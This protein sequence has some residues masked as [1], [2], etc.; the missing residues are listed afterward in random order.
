MQRPVSGDALHSAPS[1]AARRAALER[2]LRQARDGDG[3]VGIPR[4]GAAEGPL[5][6]AQRRLWL[7]EQLAPG[8][9]AYLMPTGHR[10]RGTLDAPALERALGELVR[11]HEAFRTSFVLR[12]GEPVQVVAP[13]CP[14]SLAV[15]DLSSLDAAAREAVVARHVA[16]EA[17]RPFD[18][19]RP[20]LLRATLLR[21]GPEEHVLLL[22]THHL[23]SDG[24][25][26]G[27]MMHDLAALYA[28]FAGGQAPPPGPAARYLDYATWQAERLAGD[29][30][31]RDLAYWRAQL[32]DAP[33]FLELPVDAAR[34]PVESHR[35]ALARAPL[36]PAL[37]AGVAALARGEGATPLAVH[38]AAWG[39][40]LS[41]YAGQP[42]VTVGTPLACRTRPE[43]E[44]V[45]GLFVNTLPLR[46][47][48][49]D[50]PSFRALVG[51]VREQLL[52]AQ[53]HADLPFERLLDAVGVERSLAWP[54]L[55]QAVCVRVEADAEALPLP[56]ITA[57]PLATDGP[58]A[59]FE[60]T[61]GVLEG[62]ADAVLQLEYAA[63]LFTAATAARVLEH[64]RVLLER[65]LA[66]PDRRLSRVPLLAR[67]D[68]ALLRGPA[69]GAAEAPVRECIHARFAAQAAATPD[70]VAVV[71][72][73]LRLTYRELDERAGRLAAHLRRHGAGPEV[74][75]GVCL[76]RS[77]GLI[78]AVLGVL[79]AGAA[80]VPLDPAYPP[81]RLA[82]LL[83]DSAAPLLVTSAALL[84]HLP[85]RGARAV[86]LD[87]D[88]DAIA[89]EPALAAGE[90]AGP[91]GLAYVIYTSGSTGRPKGVMVEHRQVV[92]L[93]RATAEPVG[94]RADDAWSFFHSAA[95]DM[96]VWE[97]W[98][99]LLCGAR[100]VVVP[101][102]TSRDPASLLELLARERVTVLNQTPS[103]FRLLVE[104]DARAATDGAAPEL[105]L[106]LVTFGGEALDPRALAPWVARRG[107]ARPLLG[108][109]YGITETTVHA[110]WRRITRA[111]VAHGAG[112]PIG[113]PLSDLSLYLLDPHGLPVPAGVAGE[114][115]VGGAGVARGYLGRPSL[116]AQRFLP[117]PFA[118]AAGARMYRSGDRARRLAD[119][120]LEYLGRLDQQVKV[121]GFRIEPAEVEAAL[122]TH[123]AVRR[124]L[125]AAFGAPGEAR[126][127]AYVAADPPGPGADELRGHLLPRL[128]EHMIPAAFVRVDAFPLTA[129]G[130]LDRRALPAPDFAAAQRSYLAPRTPA[131][132]LLAALW[133]EVLEVERVGVHD[134][135]F[136]LGGDSIRSIRL[137]ARLREH[138]A[139]LSLADLVRHP[140]V[141]AAAAL[142]GTASPRDGGEETARPFALLSPADRARMPEDV[143]DAYPL[144]LLQTGMLFH[145]EL[146][147]SALYHNVGS[148]RVRA[149]WD[150]ACFRDALG[151]E[152]ARHPV[153]RTSFHLAGFGE[154]LQ[155]V[156]RSV[157]LPLTVEDLR[158]LAPAEQDAAVDA[159]I[160]AERARPFAV[161][162][163]PLVRFHV[164]LRGDGTFQLGMTEHHAILDGWS[165]ALLTAELLGRYA[166]SGGEAAGAEPERC[167]YRDFVRRERQALA[168][169]DERRAWEGRLAGAV[170]GRL[171]RGAGDGVRRGAER[172]TLSGE[173][174]AAL[175]RAADQAGVP[176]K[177][178]LLAAHLRVMGALLGRREVTTGVLF[179]GRPEESGGDRLLGLFLNPLPFSLRLQDESWREL[180]RRTWRAEREILALR[181]FPAAELQRM[182]GGEPW[183]DTLFNLV[184]FRTDRHAVPAEG[185]PEV[186]EQRGVADTTFPLAAN[187]DLGSYPGRVH[188][189]LWYDAGRTAPGE[190]AALVRAYALAL[191]RIAADPGAGVGAAP[192]AGPADLARLRAWSDGGPG[193]GGAGAVHLL[194]AEQ[195][196]RTPR[197]VAL[198]W[199]GG[200]ATYAELDAW[201]GRLARA[202]ARRGVRRGSRVGVCLERSARRVAALLAVLKAGAA[203][204]ALEPEHPPGRTAALLADAGAVLL[205]TRDGVPAAAGIASVPA[206]APDG[207]E[208]DA[209]TGSPPGDAGAEAGPDD[210]ACVAYTSGSTGAPKGVAVTHRGVVRLARGSCGAGDGSREVWAQLAAVGFDASALEIW[211]ALLN[212]ARLAVPPPG[213][214]EPAEIGEFLRRS[215]VTT[216]FLTTALFNLVVDERPDALRPLARLLT[217]GEAASPDHVGRALAAHPGLRLANVYGPTENATLTTRHPAAPGDAEGGSVPIGRPVEGTHCH[218]LD[219][220]LHPAPVGM[221]GELFAGG[222]GVAA[223]YLGRPGA[224][225]ERFVPDPF[226]GLPGARMYRTGD[227]VRWRGDGVL[228]FLGRT[229]RQVKVRGVRVEPAE[230]EAALR[231]QPGVRDAV[232]DLLRGETGAARLVAWV[233]A[234]GP[235]APAPA[236]LR[237]A[238]RRTLPEAMVPAA[239]VAVDALPL[240][241]AG[242]VDRRALPDPGAAAPAR[243]PAP[244]RDEVEAALRTLWSEVLETPAV[245]VDDD[246]FDL[247]G[248]SLRVMRLVPRIREVF[249]VEL[250]I[251]DF[252]AA[253]TVAATARALA[254]REDRPGRTL[255][256]ARLFL[257]V[258]EMPEEE[259]Q[260]QLREHR[261]AAAQAAPAGSAA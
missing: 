91:A 257:Q 246:F 59:K 185:A 241:S 162:R 107:D 14:L 251:R 113:Q 155:L 119:G 83:E 1:A 201:A 69:S 255:R 66:D 36:P 19:E 170:P 141:A 30:L 199:D 226:S 189:E 139:A 11:R 242:K 143:E 209:E 13:A 140:T 116:T 88:A 216:A 253:R 240:T 160:A 103:A 243:P 224:T 100:V 87:R 48:L 178:L 81:E 109:L 60:L 5:S 188:L 152:A 49:G 41:R 57:Q 194:F 120:G 154:P 45:V 256:I 157:E 73:P 6:P 182:N 239:F 20:P 250:P 118:G 127:A 75:V 125:V 84:A 218:V 8:T 21:L 183:A 4:T 177:S 124:A 79:K 230:V 17:R 176:L 198:S 213:V 3:V 223:G 232:V 163:A 72:G 61:L 53:A 205:V 260:A 15:H 153:L 101:H 174:S 171:P 222:E 231:R 121:R 24:W 112:S 211:G 180:A 210:I 106:R 89:R 133:C 47:D 46:I 131:E 220:F 221:P 228:E 235:E 39:A 38:L 192:L 173:E 196:R 151:A 187:F 248:D 186:L 219:A 51:R 136:A 156:H 126:L 236:E 244:P 56:G 184:D 31:E 172:L 52:G 94:F 65:A 130:K 259:V 206:L 169:A 77:A 108:N 7:V 200:A 111:D 55:L 18:L 110:T 96:S 167:G 195:A 164:Q 144:S 68:E 114:L 82:Y 35:G 102:A 207:A 76:E 99:A 62:G 93:L 98:G 22:T 181:H 202:M 71:D 67:P 168:S 245:G 54:P 40:L 215:G 122:E 149:P 258:A 148:D 254:A 12:A 233:V 142:L 29:A 175:R 63:D 197:A 23:A 92:R 161:D 10:L 214:L 44:G 134:E 43:L 159:W 135:F 191:E 150:E 27:V 9:A 212:G 25:S 115:Y 261:A 145:A 50:D 147:E 227:R 37:H 166:R 146:S 158:H 104:A 26:Q 203:Y 78:V 252:F 90:G 129:H 123:P 74:R 64:L 190:A 117:D 132:A 217:G 80:Y 204:L 105:A 237:D 179:H 58:A 86:C 16:D 34:P 137:L 234:A 138:G 70:A 229:D 165:V 2:R 225:A 42:V 28:A 249:R 85:V 193:S 238:L 208:E 95:F 32:A 247:G 97:M 128:P 33:A